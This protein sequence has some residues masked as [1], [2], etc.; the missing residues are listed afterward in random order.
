MGPERGCFRGFVCKESNKVQIVFEIQ[1]FV[2]GRNK[3]N[4]SYERK[5]SSIFPGN[6]WE[7]ETT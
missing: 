4:G 7:N 3:L 1:K 6:R 5:R 2:Q